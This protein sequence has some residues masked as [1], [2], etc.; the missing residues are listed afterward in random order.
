MAVTDR[1]GQSVLHRRNPAIRLIS[2]QWCKGRFRP[3][4]LLDHLPLRRNEDPLTTR[5]GAVHE[6]G[7]GAA[8]E[9][10]LTVAKRGMIR[11]AEDDSAD[12]RR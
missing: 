8:R 2:H 1:S 12:L 3:H 6:H 9:A 5:A 10:G 11:I 4:S 7:A